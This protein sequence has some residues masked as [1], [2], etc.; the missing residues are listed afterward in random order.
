MIIKKLEF[1]SVAPTL[2]PEEKSQQHK[3]YFNGMM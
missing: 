1:K 2:F 3:T